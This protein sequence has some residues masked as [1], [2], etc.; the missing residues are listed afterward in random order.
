[1][2]IIF[3]KTYEMR[4]LARWSLHIFRD[5]KGYKGKVIGVRFLGLGI[6]WK[7][8]LRGTLEGLGFHL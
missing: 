8:P 2:Q 4:S 1:M 6:L 7:K 3:I 5:G